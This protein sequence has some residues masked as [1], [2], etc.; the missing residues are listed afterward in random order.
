LR[1]KA[2]PLPDIAA[3]KAEMAAAHPDRGG[4][5]AAFIEARKRYVAVSPPNESCDIN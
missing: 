2:Q 4:T 1:P 3:L 5:D